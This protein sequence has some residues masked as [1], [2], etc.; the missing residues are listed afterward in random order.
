MREFRQFRPTASAQPR[1]RSARAAHAD[2]YRSRPRAAMP[3][4]RQT[5]P[6]GECIEV[7]KHNPTRGVPSLVGSR[8]RHSSNHNYP[9]VV[10][11]LSVEYWLNRPELQPLSSHS[12]LFTLIIPCSPF[13]L[14]RPCKARG[15]SVGCWRA[16]P[17]AGLLPAGRADPAW[18]NIYIHSW[19][20]RKGGGAHIPV[21]KLRH[22][23]GS[24]HFGDL[25]D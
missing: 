19:V 22:H 2:R 18:C 11:S 15:A 9:L 25:V 14:P 13:S 12:L 6:A 1:A 20:G 8:L 3:S 21:A 24:R 7:T 10:R 4:R 5:A 17:G 16:L 23:A